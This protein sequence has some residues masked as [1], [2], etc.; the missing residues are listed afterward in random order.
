MVILDYLN[1]PTQGMDSSPVQ[2]LMN[3]CTRTLLPI[4]RTLPQPRMTYPEKDQW[5]L[6]KWQEQ[7]VRYFNRGT[8]DLGDLAEGDVRMKPFRLGDKVWK[9]AIVTACL[10]ETAYNVETPDGGIYLT[11]SVPKEAKQQE[12]A[13]EP[14]KAVATSTSLNQPGPVNMQPVRPQRT[15]RPPEYLKDF[16]CK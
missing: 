11:L 14:S 10:D 7:Q 4:S 15:R 13:G 6:A 8:R 2:R 12:Q 16:V 1:T 5:N 3:R 9:K